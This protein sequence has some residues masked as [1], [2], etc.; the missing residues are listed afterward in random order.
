M[1]T[2]T[3]LPATVAPLL[4][5]RTPGNAGRLAV[6][7]IAA[8][9]PAVADAQSTLD[10]PENVS[11]G[12]VA[13][14]GTV[15]FNFLHRFSR[16]PAPIHK[17][18]NAPTFTVGVGLLPWLTLGTSYLSN[19]DLIP[20]IPNEWESF[21]RIAPLQQDLG[22]PVDVF[23]QGSWNGAAKSVDGS[24]LFG[25]RVGRVKLVALAGVL[26]DAFRFGPTRA[27]IGAGATVRLS[28]FIAVSGDLVSLADR[29][30]A[31]KV[32]WSAG[33]QVGVKAS[34][35]SMSLH[36]SNV[37]GR[38]LQG[39]ARGT[40]R[41]RYGFEYTVPITLS[42]FFHRGSEPA[43]GAKATPRAA[44]TGVEKA[45]VIDLRNLRYSRGRVEVPVGTTVTWRNRDPLAHTV[46][47]DSG[48]AQPWDSGLVETER[49][50]SLT[51]D[52][53]GTFT[54][55]CTPHPFMKGTV[56]VTPAG[57]AR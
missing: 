43:D 49:T 47:A 37:A 15:Q 57:T 29:A 25:R 13:A 2:P 53:P 56:I 55:H 42:R 18:T 52:A 41:T 11:H 35:H 51:F 32:S 21:L 44:R 4:A 19:S 7:L 46:T 28:R 9:V 33:L 8:G 50:W 36:A 48:S 5:A 27:L 45:V 54:Y 22:A 39:I 26:G 38:T 14:P 10:A 3:R 40:G 23:L 17:V 31:E 6:A 1:Q 12:W 34:P 16:G 30:G 24:I 20:E